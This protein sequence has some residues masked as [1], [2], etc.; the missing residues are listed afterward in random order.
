MSR[1]SNLPR[2]GH[3]NYEWRW[4]RGENNR[5]TLHKMATNEQVGEAKQHTL[6]GAIARDPADRILYAAYL[7][8]NDQPIGTSIYVGSA[9]S[10][11]E[12]QLKE[13]LQG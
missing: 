6:N 8:G 10:L 4:H 1:S 3:E 7:T 13:K 12:D 11:V 9:K 5:W 2:I